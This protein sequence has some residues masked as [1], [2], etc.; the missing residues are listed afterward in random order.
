MVVFYCLTLTETLV[1]FVPVTK[2]T[3]ADQWTEKFGFLESTGTID[4]FAAP[5][6]SLH[7]AL[8]V[9]RLFDVCDLLPCPRRAFP[10][11]YPD[12]GAVLKMM[13]HKA[14]QCCDNNFITTSH[15]QMEEHFRGRRLSL[16]RQ[17]TRRMPSIRGWESSWWVLYD[18]ICCIASVKAIE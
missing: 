6:W 2:L 18:S 7:S 16:R 14:Q 4:A 8:I 15:L 11:I 5:C 3:E 1:I 12:S 17:R 10:R 9:A 13:V